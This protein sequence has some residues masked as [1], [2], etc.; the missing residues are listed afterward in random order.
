[1]TLAQALQTSAGIFRLN[2]IDDS[3][4]EAGILLQHILKL[5]RV[6][7][8]SEGERLLTDSEIELLQQ[9]VERRLLGEPSAY[10][11]GRKEFYGSDFYVDPRVLI[12][13]PETELLIEAALQWVGDFEHSRSHSGQPLIIA[14]IGTGCGAIAVALALGL[15]ESIIYAIDISPLALDVARINCARH[16]V[17]E[18][19]VLLQGNLLEPLPKPA[20]LVIANLPYIKTPDLASLSPEIAHFEP[21]VSIHGGEDGLRVIESLLSQLEGKILP[22][23]CLLL[24]IGRGQGSGLSSLL[25]RYIPHADCVFLS[26]YGGVK[27]VAKLTFR[28]V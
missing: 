17:T 14:D 13:R 21:L 20:D 10:I 7:L 26:D 16:N 27:R 24:E 9:L 2:C 5:S 15:P 28:Y 11:T 22:H 3:Y 25:K 19:V 12:P 6:Q 8:Y 4:L 18:Q 23:S 1:M